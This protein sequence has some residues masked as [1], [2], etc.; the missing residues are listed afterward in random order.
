MSANVFIHSVCKGNKQSGSIALTFDDGPI[1]EYTDRILT[2]LQSYNIKA[3]FFCIGHRIAEQQEIANRIFA[4]GHIIANHSYSHSNTFSIQSSSKMIDELKR[5][6]EEI[7]KI[8]GKSGRWFRPPYGVINPMVAK[9][10]KAC[11]YESI[12]WS[13]RSFDTKRMSATSLFQRVTRDLKQGDI[14]LFH[15][16]GYSTAE[17]LPRI[18]EY[19]M[20]HGLKIVRLDELIGQKPYF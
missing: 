2:I 16:N 8:T 7:K 11:G 18:I 6:E 12:G 10:I 9:A 19:T 17:A 4:A 1:P 14:I 5:T 13:I 3:T 15:D 20:K